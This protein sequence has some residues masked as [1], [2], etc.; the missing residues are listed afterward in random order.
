M[1]NTM[2]NNKKKA[3]I[4]FGLT[5]SAALVAGMVQTP[6]ADAL[7]GGKEVGNTY[8]KYG[9]GWD[10]TYTIPLKSGGEVEGFCLDPYQAAPKQ[11]PAQ[12]YGDPEPYDVSKL[13]AGD[14]NRL[15]VA[16]YLGKLAIEKEND[17]EQ[18]KSFIMQVRDPARMAD[19][20]LPYVKSWNK[21]NVAAASSVIVHEIG[22][23]GPEGNGRWGS[24][25]DNRQYLADP[26]VKDIHKQVLKLAD[27]IGSIQK[28]PVVGKWVNDNILNVKF[29]Q[30]KPDNW[31]GP[32]QGHQRMIA[33]SDI[34]IPE[35]KIPDIPNLDLDIP[36]PSDKTSRTP[37][38][39]SKSKTT[40]PSS[41]TPSVS[42]TPSTTPSVPSEETTTPSTPSSTTSSKTTTPKPD[43]SIR[44]SAGTKEEN[45]VEK[46]KTIIDTVSYEGLEK[47]KKYKLK[48][49]LVNKETG[50]KT[51]DAGETEFTAEKSKGEQDVEIKIENPESDELVVFEQL[52]DEKTDKVVAKHEDKE[53]KAQTIGKPEYTPEIRTQAESSTG[54]LIQTGT[55]V[56]DTVSYTGLEPGKSYRLEARLMCKEDG[57]DTGASQSKTFTAEETDGTV[58]V[59]N[60]A[61][62]NP[63]CTEQVVFERL[64]DEE[65]GELVAVHEDITDAAQTVGGPRSE[66]LKKKKKKVAPAEEKVTPTPEKEAPAPTPNIHQEQNQNQSAPGAPAAPAAPAPAGGGAPGGSAA[67]PGGSASAAPRQVISSVPS[68]NITHND[69]DTF[70]RI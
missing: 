53:D 70:N 29:T 60:I 18:F 55:T 12:Q 17:F 26:T 7:V 62:T 39:S 22:S 41:K 51:G 52:I 28:I 25:G 42:T 48:G 54:N 58:N 3:T 1:L 13:S 21:D 33:M 31:G 30:R 6:E 24:N 2:K 40:T 43:I 50:E 63:D 23:K 32:N 37:N 69:I 45:I 65:T 47:G 44:T 15:M 34:E 8:G 9:I 49:E 68:G 5:A 10:S 16:L 4:G 66:M 38:D 57:T 56:T 27:Q 11:A 64:Y 46:G 14:K 61:V 36:K 59:E 19:V 20:H 67:A 35:F